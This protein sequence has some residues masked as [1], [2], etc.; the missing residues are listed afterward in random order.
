[1]KGAQGGSPPLAYS[2]LS[3]RG[4]CREFGFEEIIIDKLKTSTYYF[5]DFSF[6]RIFNCAFQLTY[7]VIPVF[8]EIEK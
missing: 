1:M 4:A 7:L 3:A 2:G 6:I 5:N 8:Y